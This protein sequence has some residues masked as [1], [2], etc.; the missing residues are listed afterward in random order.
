MKKKKLKLNLKKILIRL[1]FILIVILGYLLIKYYFLIIDNNNTNVADIKSYNTIDIP[2]DTLNTNLQN[3]NFDIIAE[4]KNPNY[5]GAGQLKV[6][7]KSGYFTTFTS[8]NKMVYKEYKQN[9]TVPWANNQY[10]D[11]TME[12]DGCGITAMSIILSGYNRNYNP[13]DLR[14]Q[15]YPYLLANDISFE[16]SNS[17]G[18]K[19]SGFYFDSVHLSG[20]ELEKHLKTNR[21]ILICVWNKP[22]INRWTTVS[23][24]MVLL[25]TDGQGKVYVS[26]PN[27]LEYS[28]NSSGW[29][30]LDEITPYLAKALYINE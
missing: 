6:N 15:F 23:H 22:E 8:E 18:I 19:N 24:Y 11:G 14:K 26:N 9:G 12:T 10:W 7:E 30:N 5:S 29:Y 4:E 3:N 13:E 21:P 17:F 28:Y 25:A 1:L 2:Q 20:E 16:L 27:G